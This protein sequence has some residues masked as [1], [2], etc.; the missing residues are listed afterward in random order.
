MPWSFGTKKV[1]YRVLDGK[2]RVLIAGGGVSLS[3]EISKIS[4]IKEGALCNW[5][6][7]VVNFRLSGNTASGRIE[8]NCVERL[9]ARIWGAEE[10]RLLGKVHGALARDPRHPLKPPA[11]KYPDPRFMLDHQ[12]VRV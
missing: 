3:V 5:R 7:F 12:I 11:Q 2:Y 10:T 8:L 4:E 6:P 9:P 1:V